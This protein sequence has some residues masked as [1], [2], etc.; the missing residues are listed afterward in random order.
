MSFQFQCTDCGNVY[1]SVDAF[2]TPK[3]SENQERTFMFFFHVIFLFQCTDCGNVLSPLMRFHE[4][5]SIRKNMEGLLIVMY[6][7]SN[8]LTVVK[9]LSLLI[10]FHESNI[11]QKKLERIFYLISISMPILWK[12]FLI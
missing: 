5:K 4:S 7:N 10:R 8:E 11:I 3:A 2:M 1:S 12:S 6:H 9:F